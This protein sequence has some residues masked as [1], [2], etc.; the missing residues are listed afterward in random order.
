MKIYKLKNIYQ[1]NA[2]YYKI[3]EKV[4]FILFYFTKYRFILMICQLTVYTYFILYLCN[5]DIKF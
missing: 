4:Y 5:Y 1:N 2:L 3:N